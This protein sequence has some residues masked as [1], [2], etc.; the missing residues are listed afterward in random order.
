MESRSVRGMMQLQSSSQGSRNA[1]RPD[2]EYGILSLKW[3][4]KSILKDLGCP[5]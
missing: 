3:T 2:K 5:V 1:P 4:V